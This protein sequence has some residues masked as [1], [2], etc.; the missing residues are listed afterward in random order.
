MKVFLQTSKTNKN[1]NWER[2]TKEGS[3]NLEKSG[4]KEEKVNLFS[5][6]PSRPESLV[7]KINCFKKRRKSREDYRRTQIALE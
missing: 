3:Q 7:T 5:D 1:N 6:D 4:K 2:D